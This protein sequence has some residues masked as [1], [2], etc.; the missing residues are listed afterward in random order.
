MIRGMSSADP[1]LG[2]MTTRLK[3]AAAWKDVYPAWQVY[4]DECEQLLQFLEQSGQLERFWARLA[5]KKQQRD[6]ALNEIRVAFLLHQMGYPITSWEPTDSPPNTVEFAVCLTSGTTVYVEVKS[7]GWESELTSEEQLAG[8]VHLDKYQDG[9]GRAAGPIPVIRK[10]VEKARP[11]FS[12]RKPS[13]I[14]IT[15]DCFV[16][17]GNWGWGPLTMALTGSSL[18]WGKGLFHRPEYNT[19][20]GVCLF[21]LGRVS[22]KTGMEWRL[23]CLANPNALPGAVLPSEF[24]AQL[25]TPEEEPTASI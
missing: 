6:E 20:G 2:R 8:R 9:E 22:D 21:W 14:F 19:I 15:D 25:C 17:L 10:T 12:G 1:D 23:R 16:A 13:I 24:V 11:K 18:G 3:R 4:A 7:P 5:A